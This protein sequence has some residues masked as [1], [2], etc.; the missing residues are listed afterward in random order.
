MF[1]YATKPEPMMATDVNAK[2][3]FVYCKFGAL[4][5]IDVTST[6]CSEEREYAAGDDSAVI[7]ASR[8]LPDSGPTTAP[9]RPRE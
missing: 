7:L 5:P 4:F 6:S 2:V 9:K 3:H 8:G 1:V